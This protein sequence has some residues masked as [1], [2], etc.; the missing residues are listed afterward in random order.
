MNGD[1]A[2]GFDVGGTNTKWVLLDDE[3]ST[4]DTGTVITSRAGE[5][6]VVAQLVDLA[7]SIRDS[8]RQPIGSTGIALPGHVHPVFQTTSIVPNIAG[9]WWQFEFGRQFTQ[10]SGHTVTLLNDARAFAIAELRI[11]AAAGENDVI[12]VTVGTGVGGA[13]ALDGQVLRG[14]WDSRGEVGHIVVDPEGPLCS[15]GTRGC[16]EAFAGG[17]AL[18]ARLTARLANTVS[19]NMDEVD[20]TP[21]VVFLA[22]SRGDMAAVAVVDEGTRALATAVVNVC[23]LL[24]APMV[25]VGGG[26]GLAWPHYADAIHRELAAR[27]ALL[28]PGEVRVASLAEGAGAI[29]AAL[30]GAEESAK[31]NPRRSAAR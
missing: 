26:L 15:C 21:D 29:G 1:L 20:W 14:G 16:A 30:A 6:S 31:L 3:R 19:D 9:D 10:R 27:A 28:G 2:L 24:A 25:V 7:G 23:A 8:V 22:A 13:I 18:V 11:G 4:V 17:R 12:F 5:S